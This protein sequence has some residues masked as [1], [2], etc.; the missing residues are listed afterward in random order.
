ME[1]KIVPDVI[2]QK[3]LR[4]LPGS[5]T[6]RDAALA[7]SDREVGA[8]LVTNDGELEGIFTERDLLH[9]RRGARPRPKITQPRRGH[10]EE[11]GHD[12]SRRSMRSSR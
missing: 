3:Q 1:R 11:A 7:C 8:V 6:V 2:G 10:D 4:Q 12:R 5:A 9:A